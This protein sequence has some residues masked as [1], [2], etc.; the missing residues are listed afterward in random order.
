MGAFIEEGNGVGHKR[1][2][3]AGTRAAFFLCRLWRAQPNR[4]NPA[5]WNSL[6]GGPAKS[7]FGVLGGTRATRPRVRFALELRRKKKKWMRP[8]GPGPNSGATG[9]SGPL[10]FAANKP[11]DTGG[12]FSMAVEGGDEKLG[13]GFG[14]GLFAGADPPPRGRGPRTRG[15]FGYPILK[16]N[17]LSDGRRRLAGGPAKSRAA[18]PQGRKKLATRPRGAGAWRPYKTRAEA[19]TG[20][21]R[22]F[23]GPSTIL[24]GT[25]RPSGPQLK[26]PRS[27]GAAGRGT[28]SFRF[29]G[30]SPRNPL[31][32]NKT[33]YSI[34]I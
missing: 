14:M 21:T 8:L 12:R 19:M 6:W 11:R 23:R 30:S 13:V 18:A 16:K 9:N 15:R 2:S 29:R 3:R 27:G 33:R 28:I 5:D 34:L 20:T 4:Q 31:S 1:H 22:F 32:E 24:G 17:L 26:A 7:D 25:H 10:L